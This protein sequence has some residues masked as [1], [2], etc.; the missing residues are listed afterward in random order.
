MKDFN[1]KSGEP[2]TEA[3]KGKAVAECE[4]KD[5]GMDSILQFTFTD[6]TVLRFR[7]D[8]IYEW[9]IIDSEDEQDCKE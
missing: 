2:I 6:G 9:E 8:W 4:N 3:I 5:E 1:W 7:Y